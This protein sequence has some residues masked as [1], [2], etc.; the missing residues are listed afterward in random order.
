MSDELPEQD[1][2][3]EEVDQLIKEFGK[4]LPADR[5]KALMQKLRG[6]RSRFL[7]QQKADPEIDHDRGI[8]R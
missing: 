6:E 5:K 4:P 1:L 8:S 3:P 7:E 2:R